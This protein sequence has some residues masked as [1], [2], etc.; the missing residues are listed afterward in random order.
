VDTRFSPHRAIISDANPYIWF[1]NLSAHVNNWKLQ[2]KISN[3]EI[4]NETEFRENDEQPQKSI[5]KAE[6]RAEIL[7]P[8]PPAYE[9]GVQIHISHT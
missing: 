8:G 3:V 5:R 1:S 7:N 9:T 6:L 4:N 2:H